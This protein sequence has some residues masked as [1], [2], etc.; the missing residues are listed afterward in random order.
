MIL[1]VGIDLVEIPR[2]EAALA[3]HGERFARRVLSDV[4]FTR[5]KTEVKP[6][7]F[8]ARRFAAKEALSKALGTGIRTP[9]T[10]R[11]ISVTNHDSGSPRF[12]WTPALNEWLNKRGVRRTHISMTDER[13]LA[14]AYVVLEGDPDA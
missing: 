14:A 2:I 7:A 6:A 5:F 1:G 3:R 11:N 12:E 4:E 10:W 8:L 9:V 13:S